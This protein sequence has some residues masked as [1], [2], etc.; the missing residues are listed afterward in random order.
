[1]EYK[2][3]VNTLARKL[4]PVEAG[5]NDTRKSYNK[6]AEPLSFNACLIQ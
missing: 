6:T 3:D 1:M 4:L 2:P 5:L